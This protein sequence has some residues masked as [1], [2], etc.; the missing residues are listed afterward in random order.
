MLA[1]WRTWSHKM[2]V[3]FK[4]QWASWDGG[5]L[6]TTIS[7]IHQPQ[8][9]MA[10][11][12]NPNFYIHGNIGEKP[13]DVLFDSGAVISVIHCKLL[14]D[15]VNSM[16]TT[17]LAISAN[18]APLDITGQAILPVTLGALTVT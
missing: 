11:L 4:L 16:D 10:T 9:N 3:P 18:G 15:N 8:Q 5:Q 17:A 6:A 7:Y 14:P 12:I 13:T 1:V 2:T